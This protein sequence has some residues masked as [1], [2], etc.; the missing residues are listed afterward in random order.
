MG[1]IKLIVTSDGSHS[2][3]NEDL[4]ET[5]H[6]RHGAVQ[7]SLHVFIRNGLEKIPIANHPVNIFEVGFGT[8]LNALLALSTE[9]IINYASIEAYPLDETIFSSLN[10]APQGLLQTLHRSEWD[11]SIQITPHFTL[12][13]IK[14]DLLTA[15]IPSH[16]DIIFFDAFAPSKQP[17]MW[18]LPVLKKVCDT[19]MPGG[20]FVTYCAKGQLK[21]DLKSLGLEVETLPGPPGKKEMVRG[22]KK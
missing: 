5:Y 8:G 18:G 6:S 16:S 7:E 3:L 9:R 15:S 17:E 22:T 4:D 14:G 11:Q 10:Y 19:L 20:I 2:L 21:R 12:K 13:K 1:E